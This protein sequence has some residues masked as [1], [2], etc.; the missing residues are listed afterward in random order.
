MQLNEE[1]LSPPPR[2]PVNDEKRT[3]DDPDTLPL[4]EYVRRLSS[5]IPLERIQADNRLKQAGT[6]GLLAVAVFVGGS[7][8]DPKQLAEA[9]RFIA[10]ADFAG[11]EAD[12]A[13]TMR[14]ALARALAHTDSTVR[15]PAA[16]ALRVHGPGAQRT[17]FLTAITDPVRRVRWEVV[18]RFSDN[19][20]ELDK[21][22]R[23]ILF[24][25]LEAGKRADFT[26]ADQDGDGSLTR[27]EFSGTD[28]EFAK[29]DADA[30]AAIS[31]D[32][33]ASPIASEIRADIMA[34]LF[35]LHTKLTPDEK[36]PGYNPWLPSSDQL[37]IVQLWRNW[38]DKLS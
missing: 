7:D 31:S 24:G 18:Q 1:L 23:S 33:W 9:V 32:E 10:S 6:K 21:A 22:Q 34:L 11:L 37:D 12:Q 3:P 19:P 26:S 36:P 35:R 2:G 29:L 30:N 5:D 38:S 17:V 14:E 4:P 25:Y 15:I 20:T 16:L 27:R 13:T 28:A 8:A